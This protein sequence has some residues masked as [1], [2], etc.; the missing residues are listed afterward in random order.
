MRPSISIS[1]RAEN[2]G[3]RAD[4]HTLVSGEQSYCKGVVLRSRKAGATRGLLCGR[5]GVVVMVG[6]RHTWILLACVACGDGA[7]ARPD[8]G[9]AMPLDAGHAPDPSGEDGGPPQQGSYEFPCLW[10][11]DDA[12]PSRAATFEAVY[13][14]VFCKAGCAT[15]YCHGSRGAWADLDMT[16]ILGAYQALVGMPTGNDIPVGGRPTCRE[17]ELLRVEPYAPERS[18]LYLKVSG[19]APCGAPMPPPEA[20]RAALTEQELDQVRRWIEAGAPLSGQ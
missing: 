15:F 10:R 17:S 5:V 2:S 7:P 19:A 9:E 3:L 11:D 4:R 20:E 8:A 12:E 14:E 16:S 6:A 18:L 13:V 1:S